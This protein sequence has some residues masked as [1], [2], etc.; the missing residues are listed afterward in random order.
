MGIKGEA[1]Q[2]KD[3]DNI[4]NKIIAVN[5]HSLEKERWITQT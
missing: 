3:L 4:F 5:F 2:M 1:V